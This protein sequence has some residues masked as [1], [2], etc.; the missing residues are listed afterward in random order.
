MIIESIALNNFGTYKGNQFFDLSVKDP[1]KPVILVGAL[2][3]SGKTTFLNSIQLCLYGNH[4]PLVKSNKLPYLEFLKKRINNGVDKKEGASIKIDLTID[5]D[6]K[7]ENLC[8]ERKWFE[9]ENGNIKEILTIFRDGEEDLAIKANWYDYIQNLFPLSTMPLFFFDGEKIEDLANPSKSSDIIRSAINGLLGLD[10]IDQCKTNLDLFTSRKAKELANDRV[11]DEIKKKED[12]IKEEEIA[13]GSL[14]SD[15]DKIGDDLVNLSNKV[16]ESKALYRKKGGESFEARERFFEQKIDT[17]ITKG[18]EINSSQDFMAGASPLSLVSEMLGEIIDLGESQLKKKS[19][20]DS[21]RFLKTFKIK[22]TE[23]PNLKNL[24]ESKIKTIESIFNQEISDLESYKASN[25]DLNVSASSVEYLKEFLNRGNKEIRSSAIDIVKSIDEV[26]KKVLLIEKN[27]AS[28]PTE[29]SILPFKEVVD[30]LIGSLA[31]LNFQ[32]KEKLKIMEEKEKKLDKLY[33]AL[34][35]DINELVVAKNE[36]NDYGRYSHFSEK[37]K[38]TF[39][40]F[41]GALIDR[42]SEQIESEILSC[43]DVLV[44][45]EKLISKLKLNKETFQLTFFDEND[46]EILYDDLSSGERQLLAISILWAL[47]K[48]SNQKLPV[49]IDTPLGRLDSENRYN[50]SSNYF[51]KASHQIILLSTD[52]EMVDDYYDLI[53]PSISRTFTIDYSKENGG[54]SIRGGYF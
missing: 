46:L 26:S 3:G 30:E 7:S 15:F 47:S 48:I 40:L 41:K 50:L 8:I 34:K 13:M 12:Q 33:I 25:D 43:F 23:D 37:A 44:R 53:K 51:H 36:Q 27:I 29:E 1:S 28:I 9:N 38:T 17:E 16:D 5:N 10:I 21:A 2:N 20:E 32:K 4:A 6:A 39:D 52:E 45:K 14:N 42:K 54:S 35:K 24:E 31:V 19:N 18:A 49:I 11:L 22:F